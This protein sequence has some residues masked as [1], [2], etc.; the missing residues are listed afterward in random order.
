LVV[1]ANGDG[2]PEVPPVTGSLP[3]GIPSRDGMQGEAGK[4]AGAEQEA[5]AGLEYRHVTKRK[6][7]R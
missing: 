6:G 4:T 5:R 1:S 7:A 3:P 2:G